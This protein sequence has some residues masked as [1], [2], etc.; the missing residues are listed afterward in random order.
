MRV[1]DLWAIMMVVC[2]LG[3]LME[4]AVFHDYDAVCYAA[5]CLVTSCAAWMILREMEEKKNGK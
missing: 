4:Y 5:I 1:S 2:A 3:A